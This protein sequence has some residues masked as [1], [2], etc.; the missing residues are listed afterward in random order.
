MKVQI[1][2]VTGHEAMIPNGIAVVR[3][4]TALE[5]THPS[6]YVVIPID[7]VLYYEVDN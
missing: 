1:R 6:G 7:R 4:T 3:T 5:V 2:L